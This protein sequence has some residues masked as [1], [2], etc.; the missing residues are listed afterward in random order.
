L[1][2]HAHLPSPLPSDAGPDASLEV[3]LGEREAG[4]AE[5]WCEVLHLPRV[6]RW[7]NFFALGGHSLS[8]TQVVSRV[9]A[10]WQT[11]LPL[12]ALFDDPTLQALATRPEWQRPADA[13]TRAQGRI[14]RAPR[15][16]PLR[17]SFSQ[18]RMWLVQQLNPQTTAYNMAFTVRLRGPLDAALLARSLDCVA[19]QHEA[20][21]T[22]FISVDGEPAQ[23][24]TP[25]PDVALGH[26]DLR[27]WPDH[28]REIEAR[29][30][31]RAVTSRRFDLSV[32]GLHSTTLLQLDDTDHVLMW[33]MHH[34]IGDQWAAGVLMRELQQ[35]YTALLQNQ[36]I[37]LAPPAVEFA[38]YAEWQRQERQQAALDLQLNFWSRRL[39][40]LQPLALPTDKPRRG[41][42]GGSGGSVHMDLGAARLAAVKQFS[43]R[44]GATPFMTLLACFDLMLARYS[45]Q[46]DIAVGV[47][48]A[49]RRSL[50]AESLVG[51]LVNTVVMRNH[52]ANGLS[53]VELLAGVRET[54]LQ[55]YAN[56]DLPFNT[57][58]QDLAQRRDRNFS[59]LVQ[60]MFNV[61][62]APYAVDGFAGLKAEAFPFNQGAAQFD[63]SLAVDTETFGQIHLDYAADLFE[64]A[65]ATR[66]L[67][68]YVTL[69]DQ[70]LAD[71]TLTVLDFELV[72][73]AERA[74]LQAWNATKLPFETDLRLGDLI[75]R[76]VLKAG[77]ATAAVFEGRRVSYGELDASARA[78][79]L[80]LRASGAGPG[81]LVGV[82]LERSIELVTALVGVVYSGAAYVPLDP[83]YPPARLARM[84]E[85]AGMTLVVS[86]EDELRRLR[87][88][89]PQNLSFIDVDSV[90]PA[91]E[92][93][94]DFALFGHADDPAYV[95]F[96]SGSTGRPKGAMNAHKGVVNWLQWMQTE[97][98]L[99]PQDRVL[100]KTPYSFDVSLREFFWP[101]MTGA[102]IVVARPDGHRDSAYLIDLIRQQSITLLH[103]VPSMLHI[104]LDEPGI[105]QCTSVQ[106]VVCSGEA[107]SADAVELFFR[108]MPHSRLCN[109]YGPTEAAVEVTFWECRPGDP[110]GVASS[111]PIGR[112]VANTQMHVLDSRLRLQPVGVPGEL[113]IGGV[114]VGMGYVSRPDLTAERFIPDPFNPGERLYKTGDLARWTSNGVIDY[115]GRADDQVKI[116]GHRI[117]LGEIESSLATHADVARCVVI[118]REDAPGDRRLVAYVAPRGTMSAAG[119]LREHLRQQ[120]PE[121]M[122]PQHVVVLES[123][124]LLPN[125]KI[126]RA[127]L[128]MPTDTAVVRDSAFWVPRTDTEVALAQIW[129]RLLGIDRV[130]TTDNFFDL[131]GHSLLAMRAVSDIQKALGV[132][133]GV[134]RL[135]F[136]S[137]AQLAAGLDAPN[138]S[139]RPAAP[140]KASTV[141][142]LM[143]GLQRMLLSRGAGETH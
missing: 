81:A 142:Y 38:D 51:T 72:G 70:V 46:T 56:Q 34:S 25:H 20:F 121:Y 55:A 129:E 42:I 37:G 95:I 10:R 93:S 27:A 21:R 116:R 8:A 118:V 6:D 9:R 64:E 36:P 43:T 132:R 112:P 60:V 17:T 7:D 47:P 110:S 98:T 13:G 82:C 24:I 16:A 30:V 59:P 136:E 137:L 48:I 15:D 130:S 88:A 125:G 5:I 122:V 127:A 39:E 50:A 131:G 62:N 75:R 117:E 71:P 123:I 11:E 120:V 1:D 32:A 133:I 58:V 91:P 100:L 40:G 35:V 14:H 53:F 85:D 107:L 68:G 97:Y 76:Q 128:P 115:L 102:S 113:Y 138:T 65:S 86:R 41:P 73:Y 49:N 101:L 12:R 140:A 19:R 134:R 61:L 106:R 80:R 33:L 111:V 18:R 96:T 94:A 109:L 22:R 79:A 84:C 52:V 26:V 78:L 67:A 139:V 114:Q 104:F 108:R 90:G 44:H 45:G 2:L 143:S 63:L 89:L 126:D 31:L 83:S 69:L 119:A 92:E 99:A 29:R 74:E 4:L 54:A 77:D 141:K 23:V 87:S 105:E 3:P 135:L 124:P 28:Q 57:L 66:M 103:F